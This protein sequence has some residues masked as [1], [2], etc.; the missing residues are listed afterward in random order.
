MK[1]R[2]Q[3]Y[4]IIVVVACVVGFFRLQSDDAVELPPVKPEKQLFEHAESLP[5]FSGF[6]DVDAKKRAFF[7]FLLP[8]VKQ[9]NQRIETLRAHL[10]SLAARVDSLRENELRW[11]LQLAQYYRV[12]ASDTGTANLDPG[13]VI[14]RLLLRV[15]QV[16]PSLALAQAANESAWGTSR[17]AREGNNLYGQW[18]FRKGCGLVPK[19]RP[20]GDRHEVAKFSS[21]LHSVERY[22]HN[23]NTH[24]AYKEFRLMRANQREAGA[25]LSGKQIA[26]TLVKYST[27]GAEYVEELRAMIRLNGLSRY[28]HSTET[29]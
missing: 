22:I 16:P 11:L 15:D 20:P 7:E 17:F 29:I 2:D 28:D 14:D 9:E 23:L 19:D 12:V 5:D 6:E 8:L 27:R 24:L 26:A 3:I 13:W 1:A 4:L 10:L 25:A 21:P 18:C